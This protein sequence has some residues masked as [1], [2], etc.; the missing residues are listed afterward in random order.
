MWAL[1]L[2]VAYRGR[3]KELDAHARKAATED[4]SD[5]S[6]SWRPSPSIWEKDHRRLYQASSIFTPIIYAH[7]E[8]AWTEGALDAV[9]LAMQAWRGKG[10]VKGLTGHLLK[11]YVHKPRP[12]RRENKKT[13]PPPRYRTSAVVQVA[14]LLVS[15]GP[16]LRRLLN[17][18]ESDDEA[19][20]ME[21]AIADLEQQCAQL[22]EELRIEQASA[23]RL[24][25]AWRKAAGRLKAKNTA[26][27]EARRDE[28]SKAK[29]QA[30]QQVKTTKAELKRSYEELTA[31]V[32]DEVYEEFAE[33]LST[34]RA[35]AR[36]VEKSAS[37]SEGRKRRLRRRLVV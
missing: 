37:L 2:C 4:V 26:V 11:N 19:K 30:K 28:R 31:G 23:S 32:R 21:E 17:I 6:P 13:P 15:H 9:G 12:G 25:D 8:V 34:A 22:K 24:Q 7:K 16:Q 36:R 20:P 5:D 18:K 35:R 29:E 33:R 14:A 27:T 3:V 10:H 1:M